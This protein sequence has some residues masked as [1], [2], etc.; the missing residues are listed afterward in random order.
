MPDDVQEKLTPEWRREIVRMDPRDLMVRYRREADT[1]RSIMLRRG[2]GVSSEWKTFKQFLIDVG[3]CPSP[4]HLLLP[5]Y[6]NERSYG[7]GKVRWAPKGT[8]PKPAPARPPTAANGGYGQWTSLSGDTVSVTSLTDTLKTPLQ[9][10]LMA[11][12]Q[13]ATADAVAGEVKNA[14]RMVNQKAIWLPAD[15]KRR[16]TFFMAFRAWR[17][18]VRPEV[19][20]HATPAFLFLYTCLPVMRDSRDELMRIDLWKPL[21]HSKWSAREAHVAWKRYCEMMPRAQVALSEVKAY[22]SFSLESELD[23]LCA[24]IVE[25]EKRM[26]IGPKARPQAA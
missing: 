3:P 10:I 8:K 20:Q 14:D 2:V 9:P 26:R 11:M 6:E 4:D 17:L 24:R 23:V 19:Q 25:A 22:A 18:A 12:N 21:T 5:I 1:H 16:E 7:P 15:E 13:G